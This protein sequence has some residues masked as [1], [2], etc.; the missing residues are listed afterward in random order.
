M[1]SESY[2]N[3]HMGIKPFPETR[4][5]K[6]QWLG[7]LEIIVDC[8]IH[9][10][11]IDIFVKVDG[12]SDIFQPVWGFNN[13]SKYRYVVFNGSHYDS[14][15]TCF[16]PVSDRNRR[17]TKLSSPNQTLRFHNRFSGLDE[18]SDDESV[19]ES[20]H[21]NAAAS[22]AGSE[23]GNDCGG[24]L[25]SNDGIDEGCVNVSGSIGSTSFSDP[26]GNGDS[27]IW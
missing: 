9:K 26:G 13:G 7:P 27:D 19:A 17:S 2:Y 24:E 8:L 4:H 25:D 22:N 23:L 16:T 1:T 18:D 10:E 6:Y 20:V 3:H 21:D 5:R 14:L 11:S 15:G 12:T